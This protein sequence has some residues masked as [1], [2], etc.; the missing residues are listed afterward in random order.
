MFQRTLDYCLQCN[1]K[2]EY[3]DREEEGSYCEKCKIYMVPETSREELIKVRDIEENLNIMFYLVK[4]KELT[5]TWKKYQKFWHDNNMDEFYVYMNE[6]MIL[7]DYSPPTL[8]QIREMLVKYINGNISDDSTRPL[9]ITGHFAS[10]G[11]LTGMMISLNGSPPKAHAIYSNNT[12]IM[13][14][15]TLEIFDKCYF[16]KGIPELDALKDIFN[17]NNSYKYE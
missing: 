16:M 3:T 7:H 15:S 13:T 9:I 17:K 11:K 5:Y 2:F 12:L 4:S 6:E 14:S 10:Y 1:T 8:K